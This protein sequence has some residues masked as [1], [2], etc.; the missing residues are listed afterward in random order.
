MEFQQDELIQ[1]LDDKW[2]ILRVLDAE[3]FNKSNR[4]S[5]LVWDSREKT[6]KK[7]AIHPAWKHS[8]VESFWKATGGSVRLLPQIRYLAQ[9]SDSGR[10]HIMIFDTWRKYDD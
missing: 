8:A 9:W 10:R 5:L 7:I 6:Q 3:K 1:V 2:S 4:A